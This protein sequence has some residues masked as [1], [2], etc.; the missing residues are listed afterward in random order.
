M[1]HL[2]TPCKNIQLVRVDEEDSF[3]DRNLS[4]VVYNQP[5]SH[6]DLLV[7]L[8]SVVIFLYYMN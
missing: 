8:F 6:H 1:K 4:D 2:K 3:T 7:F 5:E